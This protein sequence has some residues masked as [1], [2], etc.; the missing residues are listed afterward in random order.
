MAV[1]T[2]EQSVHRLSVQAS[3]EEYTLAVTEV[4]SEYPKGLFVFTRIM[5][6]KLA[7]HDVPLLNVSKLAKIGCR[8]RF[9]SKDD[10]QIL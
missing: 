7:G 9:V 1:L 3:P 10:V 4:L 6:R 2:G 5:N 8:R